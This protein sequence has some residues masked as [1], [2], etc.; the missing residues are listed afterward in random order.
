MRPLAATLALALAL[1][2]APGIA[3]GL[4]VWIDSPLGSDFVYG[5]VEFV[6]AVAGQDPVAGVQF[7][8]DGRSLGEVV[9]APYRITVDV[10][11]D[12][13]S[14]EFKVV[15]RSR[16]GLT[17]SRTIETPPLKI[18][19]VVDL[20]LQQLYVTVTREAARVLDFSR[21]DFR[22]RDEGRPQAI[23][24][25]E[26]GDIPLTA[27]LLLDCSRSM[28]GDRLASAL[29][30]ARTFVDGMKPLDEA[31]VLLF[32]DRLLRATE[33]SGDRGALGQALAGVRA[34]GGTAINDHLFM[35]LQRLDERQ[36]RRVVVLLSDGKDVHSVLPMAEVL[37]K[38]RRSPALIYW[39]HLRKSG[40]GEAPPSY[41]SSW[42]GVEENRTEF[43]RLR[44][45]V[46]E[47]GGR[48]E[49]LE[50]PED[51]EEAFAGILAELRE[52]YVLGYYPS[53]AREDGS[54]HEVKLRVARPGVKIRTRE[55][56]FDY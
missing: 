2:P 12:N 14:H 39:I 43:L 23:V 3:A 45:A 27:V 54:W 22:I 36:G 9:R 30:G 56:Y 47:S 52:Q 33:F 37:R 40:A 50:H 17:A 41:S 20:E 8:L 44:E 53:E 16:T 35:S 29:Q 18:D 42:R 55:G 21:E 31:M 10:G 49:L 26:R 32:S 48:V 25:F 24:T 1:P 5:P 34:V 46:A 28:T 51:L 4:Q 6:A 11:H 15:A 19:E 7:F 13:V 38:A